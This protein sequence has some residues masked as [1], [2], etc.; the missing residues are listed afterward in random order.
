VTKSNETAPGGMNESAPGTE[1]GAKLTPPRS[2][3]DLED[4]RRE[5]IALRVKLG[6][7][8][9]AGHRCSNL[10]EQLEHYR[11]AEGEQKAHLSKNIVQQMRELTDLSAQAERPQ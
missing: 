11:T 6:A 10:V 2:G 3:F 4:T 7:D 8:T 9:P 5:L 1:I